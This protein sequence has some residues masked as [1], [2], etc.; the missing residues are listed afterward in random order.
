MRISVITYTRYGVHTANI[1]V[2]KA[3]YIATAI[4]RN[5]EYQAHQRAGLTLKNIASSKSF[6][7]EA[8]KNHA[9]DLGIQGNGWSEGLTPIVVSGYVPTFLAYIPC[10]R[11]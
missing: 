6:S 1:N 2:S 10:I 3:K 5:L 9:R 4:Y 11:P 8:T 7:G